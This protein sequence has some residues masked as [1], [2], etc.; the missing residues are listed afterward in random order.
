MKTFLKIDYY[1]QLTVFLTYILFGI[2]YGFFKNKLF[3]VWIAFYFVVGGFQL[4]SYIIRIFIGSWNDL[5]IRFYGFMIV[6]IWIVLLF[7]RLGITIDMLSF[8]PAYGL[9]T[10]PFLS[11]TYLLYCREKFKYY[12][13]QL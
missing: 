13:V 10:S 3:T 1:L 11:I 2:T 6:P 8:I 4:V 5:F 12:T 9:L 7:D